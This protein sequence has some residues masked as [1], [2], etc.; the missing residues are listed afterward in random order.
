MDGPVVV[1]F[2]FHDWVV[3]YDFILVP[4]FL[5]HESVCDGHDGAGHYESDDFLDFGFGPRQSVWSSLGLG[6]SKRLAVKVKVEGIKR[7]I[8]DIVGVWPSESDFGA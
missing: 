1:A 6:V 5:G 2:L 4:A 3:I 7:R 8:R